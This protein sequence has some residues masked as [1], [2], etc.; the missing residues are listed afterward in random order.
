M[1]D[2]NPDEENP[3]ENP[4][5]GKPDKKPDKK[6]EETAKPAPGLK[7]NKNGTY[8]IKKGT[9]PP[10]PKFFTNPSANDNIK[11]VESIEAEAFLFGYK[12]YPASYSGKVTYVGPRRILNRSIR[13]GKRDADPTK[14]GGFRL[15][16]NSC[17]LFQGQQFGG[18]TGGFIK[19]PKFIQECYK[20]DNLDIEWLIDLPLDLKETKRAVMRTDDAR[21]LKLPPHVKGDYIASGQKIPLNPGEAVQIMEMLKTRGIKKEYQHM[22]P[23]LQQQIIKDQTPA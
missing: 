17:T 14:N 19:D 23:W 18:S 11:A 3:E 4:D 13:L 22:I 16:Y 15:F 12:P 6:P 1:A 20:T 8:K 5:A 7:L 10:I 21:I 2:P 9:I